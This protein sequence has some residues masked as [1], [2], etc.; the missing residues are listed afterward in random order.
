MRPIRQQWASAR[1]LHTLYKKTHKPYLLKL[2]QGANTLARMN[3][4]LN[5]DTENDDQHANALP[6]ATSTCSPAPS[7]SPA[8]NS[9]SD[10][11]PS[12]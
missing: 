11:E 2:A 8:P 9:P 3:R 10:A 12:L 4:S 7:I 6:S 1:R 5:G